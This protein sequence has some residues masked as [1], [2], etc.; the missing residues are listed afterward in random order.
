MRRRLRAQAAF[1]RRVIAVLR[2]H[3][4]FT[5]LAVIIAAIA[6]QPLMTRV[7]VTMAIRAASTLARADLTYLMRTASLESSLNP[8]A[9]AKTGSATGLFQFIDQTWLELVGRH[10]DELGLNHYASAVR[11]GQLSAPL[12]ARILDLRNDPK[13]AAFMAAAY[14]AQNRRKLETE[15]GRHVDDVDQY[16]AHFLGPSGA[17]KFLGALQSSPDTPAATLLPAAA[18]T[19]RDVFFA[20]ERPHTVR[21]V[22]DLISRRFGERGEAI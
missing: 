18:R 2:R 8:R 6:V 11:Q 19:N 13:A 4:D 17:V 7:Q 22:H 10:G 1:A 20:G 5:L 9:R 14:A 3:W 12:R 21:E 16:F 15:L